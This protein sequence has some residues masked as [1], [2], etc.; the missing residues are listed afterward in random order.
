MY[1]DI[2]SRVFNSSVFETH[3]FKVD[4]ATVDSLFKVESMSCLTIPKHSF[5]DKNFIVKISVLYQMTINMIH[6]LHSE[7][8]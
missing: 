1:L 5:F 2:Y 8:C 4:S 7:L 3:I 6:S